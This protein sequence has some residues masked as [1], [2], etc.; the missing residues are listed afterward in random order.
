[1]WLQTILEPPSSAK[2]LSTC[3]VA[4]WT[5][6]LVCPTSSNSTIQSKTHNLSLK[7]NSFLHSLVIQR[8]RDFRIFF[9][10]FSFSPHSQSSYQILITLAPRLS[11]ICFFLHSS[12]VLSRISCS[13]LPNWTVTKETRLVDLT[14]ISGPFRTNSLISH[15]VIILE[16]KPGLVPLLVKAA[17]LS[18]IFCEQVS[19]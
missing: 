18:S 12:S 6:P 4:K 10:S 15:K 7:L 13:E 1:M 9:C 5:P 14:L 2:T 17:C 11:G 8:R 16:Q 3:P 19:K